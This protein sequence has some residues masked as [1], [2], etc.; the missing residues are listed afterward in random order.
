MQ[1][2]SAG[3]KKKKRQTAKKPEATIR[4]MEVDDIAPVYHLGSSL[5]TSEEFPILYRTWDPYEV[6]GYFTSDPDFCLVAEVEGKV[7][8][9]VLATTV[10]KEGTTWKKYGYISWMGVEESFQGTSLTRR[11]FRE[12]ERRLK[13]NKVRMIIADTEGDNERAID[14]FRRQGFSPHV[15][16]VWLVKTLG[17]PAKTTTKGERP[18]ATANKGGKQSSLPL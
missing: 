1:Q 17:Q 6:T 2:R 12:L 18:R 10:E 5:F 13:E 11:L 3:E 7:V 9:F 8:G 4:Q 14:F 16:H 15:E